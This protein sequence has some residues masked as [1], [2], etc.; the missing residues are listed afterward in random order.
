MR[1]LPC[2]ALLSALAS[3]A[4]HPAAQ[5]DTPISHAHAVALKHDAAGHYRLENGRNVRLVLDEQHLYL[6]LNHHFRRQ[7]FPAGHRLL[8]S[9]D[10]KLTVQ[11][12]PDGPVKR[13]LIQHPEL[14]ASVRLG[15]RSWRGW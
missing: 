14:P 15:E 3:T 5:A 7:L 13:I 8:A 10:G 4:L 11:Y 2:L 6:D 9:R 12:L 1:A